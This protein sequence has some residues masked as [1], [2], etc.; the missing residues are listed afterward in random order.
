MRSRYKISGKKSFQDLKL[1][2]KILAAMILAG[3]FLIRSLKIWQD[4]IYDHAK[5]V[6]HCNHIIMQELMYSCQDVLLGY[7]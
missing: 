5:L 2:D 6:L 1:R 7:Q 3:M 4:H